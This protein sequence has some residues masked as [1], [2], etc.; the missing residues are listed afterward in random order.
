MSTSNASSSSS[1]LSPS[2]SKSLPSSSGS[3][4]SSSSP[5]KSS[6]KSSIVSALTF[7]SRF[8]GVGARLRFPPS[9]FTAARASRVFTARGDRAVSSF[10]RAVVS[11]SK[12]TFSFSSRLALAAASASRRFPI[13]V[14]TALVTPRALA[15]AS[16]FVTGEKKEAMER[17]PGAGVGG[18]LA[19]PMTRDA[20]RGGRRGGDATK[21]KL[22]S[23]GARRR[24]A[25]GRPRDV[26]TRR[27]VGCF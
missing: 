1:S 19:E 22:F 24:A 13:A 8:F 16:L 25:R 20:T 9:F 2:R 17:C 15:F 21:K 4:S 23:R 7:D 14:D 5:S 12:G 6:S 10:A 18:F 27:C 3:S 26:E 11:T